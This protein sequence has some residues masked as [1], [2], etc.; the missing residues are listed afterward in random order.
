MQ[1]CYFNLNK[2]VNKW[3]LKLNLDYTEKNM[4]QMISQM[5]SMTNRMDLKSIRS[6]FDS[7]CITPGLISNMIT[8]HVLN[9]MI[10]QI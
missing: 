6:Y 5:V 9:A 7:I 3:F 4:L 8:R 1:Y 10:Y 2:I